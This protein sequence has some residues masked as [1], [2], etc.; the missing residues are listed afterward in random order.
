MSFSQTLHPWRVCRLGYRAFISLLV[1]GSFL[2]PVINSQPAHAQAT[3]Y[4]QMSVEKVAET[5][6][7]RQAAFKGDPEAQKQY[8]ALIAE[9]AAQLQKCRSQTWPQTQAIW[10]R[11][12]PC[13]IQPGVLEAVLDRIVARGYNQVYVEF[14]YDG[15]VLI[16]ESENKTAWPSAV[17]VPG[18][19][20]VDL[21]AKSIEKGRERGLKVYAWL[22][23]M[24]FGY[25]YAQLPN[26]QSALAR[27]ANG[28]TSNSMDNGDSET[29]IKVAE[30]DVSKVFIDPYNP[31]ARR[32]Y[33]DVV[34]AA[35]KRR[36]DGV[37]FDYV[38]YPRGTGPASVVSRVQDLWIYS[39]AT[40]QL[41]LQRALNKKGQELIKRYV[42]KGSISSGDVEEVNKL[43]P[44][45]AE[46]LWQGRKPSSD[47]SKS[48]VSVSELQTELWYLSVAHAVQ[49]VVDFLTLAVQPVQRQGIPAGAVFFPGGN[50]TVGQGGYDSRLQPWD[51]FPSSIEWHPMAY[52]NC[53]NNNNQCILDEVQRVLS[54]AP[55]GTKVIPALAG[56]WGQPITN[57]P[58]LESQM[59]AIRRAFPQINGVSHFAYSWQEPEADRARKFCKGD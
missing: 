10:L 36:P 6:K 25:T 11:L 23:T 39:A 44:N 24:N 28:Q 2:T 55:K 52:G 22:F 7:L 14:F 45:E 48:L 16:P 26:R 59:Q 1:S 42:S 56:N 41:L 19:E 15:Q 5:D 32:D 29:D 4:C 58:P 34:N 20:D 38:R 50:K 40:Q 17:R 30:G 31:Q 13:D 12:Y 54:M 37:L 47:S 46:P 53:G 18:F 9:H 27:K 43:Y 21:F 33:Q 8:Q 3:A 49:G 35:L 57:R 51:R